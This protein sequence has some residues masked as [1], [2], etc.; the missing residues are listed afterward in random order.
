MTKW[1]QRDWF[2][3][4]VSGI[5]LL[6]FLALFLPF[7]SEILLAAVIALAM[8]PLMGK[9]IERFQLRWRWMV[10]VVLAVLFFVIATP[11]TIVFYK[12][13]LYFSDISQSGVQNTEFFQQLVGFKNGLQAWIGARLSSFGLE[14]EFEMLSSTDDWLSQ[15]GNTLIRIF[16]GTVYRAPRI[17]LSIFIYSAALFFFLSES[18]E[19][20]KL[21]LRQDL[22]KPEEAKRF[23]A[24]LQRSSF[25]T[26][27][28]SF[29]IAILQGTVMA[30]GAAI[31]G[32]GDFTIV[33]VITFC[34]AFIPMV[35][36][37]P[38]GLVLAAY[39]LILSQYSAAIGLL[40]VAAIAGTLD[41]LLR[42]YLLSTS[43]E[44]IHPIVGLLCIIGA[45]MV[46]GMPGVFLGP[47]IAS[48]AYKI[49]PTLYGPPEPPP[50]P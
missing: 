35:G 16:T 44:D 30:T 19:I 10:A 13:Y 37:G 18:Q 23:I 15:A 24:V 39:Q 46:F 42:P 34:C 7:Y 9:W 8:E 43:D 20:K 38:V 47:V 31:F 33:W 28:T 50:K 12:T 48:V 26:V 27:V 32:V 6:S 25:S 41:N 14:T 2:R 3:G 40:V 4:L 21:F 22:L 29:V 45:V 36:A 11:I 49:I 5:F 1:T 17:L